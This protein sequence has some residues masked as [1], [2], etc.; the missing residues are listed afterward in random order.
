MMDVDRQAAELL[1]GDGPPVRP[2]HPLIQ[3][4]QQIIVCIGDVAVLQGAGLRPRV[5]APVQGGHEGLQ[6][7]VQLILVPCSQKV[8]QLRGQGVGVGTPDEDVG[9]GAWRGG[10]RQACLLSSSAGLCTQ[11]QECEVA[12]GVQLRLCAEQ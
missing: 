7:L 8:L 9:L 12:F 6:H 5:H 1:G 4:G 3:L 10:V 11:A 2:G